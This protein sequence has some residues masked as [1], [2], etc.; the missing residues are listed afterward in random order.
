MCH[1]GEVGVKGH[2]GGECKPPGSVLCRCHTRIR[3]LRVA[4][5]GWELRRGRV[6]CGGLGGG[7]GRVQATSHCIMQAQRHK[8]SDRCML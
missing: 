8:G 2:D 6:P 3:Q 5:M 7:W 4:G 1:W